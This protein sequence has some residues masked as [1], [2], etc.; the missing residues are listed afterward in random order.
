M[1]AQILESSCPEYA[2]RPDSPTLRSKPCAP[3]RRTGATKGK[4]LSSLF[5]HPIMQVQTCITPQVR[6]IN[7][8]RSRWYTE[9]PRRNV[10]PSWAAHVAFHLG[11][12]EIFRRPVDP[13]FVHRGFELAYLL[14][15]RIEFQLRHVVNVDKVIR[16]LRRGVKEVHLG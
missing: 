12:F 7:I 3:H 2:T 6:P 1:P 14:G 13:V 11:L 10:H 8:G 4:V 9:T 15:R 16:F 5:Y